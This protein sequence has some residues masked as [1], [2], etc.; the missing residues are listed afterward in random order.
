MKGQPKHKLRNFGIVILNTKWKDR[1]CRK[2]LG[3]YL[4]EILKQKGAIVRIKKANAT[5]KRPVN[6][7]FPTEY[8][9]P[10]TNQTDKAREQKLR[11]EAATIDELKR[12]CD[13]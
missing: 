7:L 5:L 11:R 1:K 4:V 13:C 9:Y 12:K 10:D 8:T 6:K 2:N 3:Y